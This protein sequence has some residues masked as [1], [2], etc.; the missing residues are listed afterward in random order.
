MFMYY[1]WIIGFSIKTNSDSVANAMRVCTNQGPPKD[2]GQLTGWQG[3]L[4][5]Q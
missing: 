3:S 5:T 4:C 1:G 2:Q